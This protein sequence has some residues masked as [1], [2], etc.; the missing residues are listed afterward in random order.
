MKK[1]L[2][3]NLIL[4]CDWVSWV[5][6]VALPDMLLTSIKSLLRGLLFRGPSLVPHAQSP[7]LALFFP[8]NIHY[9]LTYDNSLVM[10]IY[11]YLLS[12]KGKLHLGGDLGVCNRP[13]TNLS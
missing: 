9:L 7:Y 12:L 8:F 13:W 5:L 6:L 10:F 1:L 4:R 2:V 3:A 11:F